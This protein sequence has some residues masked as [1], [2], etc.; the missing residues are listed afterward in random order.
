MFYMYT[1]I[2]G[3]SAVNEPIFATGMMV[4]VIAAAAAVSV[5]Y[6]SADTDTTTHAVTCG[7]TIVERRLRHARVVDTTVGVQHTCPGNKRRCV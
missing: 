6:A 7:V 4:T 2:F 3:S 1:C 5:I